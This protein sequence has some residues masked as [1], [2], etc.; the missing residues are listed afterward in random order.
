MRVS[1]ETMTDGLREQCTVTL[2]RTCQE[3]FLLRRARGDYRESPGMRLTI[4]EAM[5]LWDLDQETCEAL[6]KSLVDARFLELDA[7][8][9][10]RRAHSGY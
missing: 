5:R 2:H 9:R 1:G 4:D 7:H 3:D 10:Y 6:L 8:G